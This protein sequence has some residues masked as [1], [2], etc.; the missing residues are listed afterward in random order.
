MSKRL[1][2]YFMRALL[3]SQLGIS[4]LAIVAGITVLQV[5]PWLI[6]S[7]KKIAA[8]VDVAGRAMTNLD[9]ASKSLKKASE[10]ESSYLNTALPQLTARIN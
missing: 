8:T 6:V 4:F 9:A 3:P 7:A 10:D 1:K 5:R 2:A